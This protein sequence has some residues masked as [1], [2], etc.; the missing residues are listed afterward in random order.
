MRRPSET[1]DQIQRQPGGDSPGQLSFQPAGLGD[2]I[3]WRICLTLTVVPHSLRPDKGVWSLARM[4]SRRA[5]LPYGNLFI[6]TRLFSIALGASG[7]GISFGTL[8]NSPPRK[9]ECTRLT[10][11]REAALIR[12]GDTQSLQTQF[13]ECPG[14]H[15]PGDISVSSAGRK[16]NHCL[17]MMKCVILITLKYIAQC[18]FLRGLCV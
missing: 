13:L 18:H 10:H 12:V 16:I 6:T 17:P 15:Q 1:Q 3:L 7:R 4:V 8:P 14:R 11:D 9:R 2:V 5:V